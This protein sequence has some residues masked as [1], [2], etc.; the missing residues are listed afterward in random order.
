M[1][2]G[3][4]SRDIELRIAA[5]TSGA[6]QVKRLAEQIDSLAK[7]GG[8]AAPEFRRLA[9]QLREV[10]KQGDALA[11]VQKIEQQVAQTS[12][13][14]KEAADNVERLR[15]SLASQEQTTAGFR[16]AQAQAKAA[17]EG[18][19]AQLRDLQAQLNTIRASY[20]GAER[21]SDS[22]RSATRELR[23][24]I[25]QVEN[26]LAS[27]KAAL[28]T[29]NEELR[30]SE[31]DLKAASRSY[32]GTA[33]SAERL[34]SVIKRQSVALDESKVSLEK[35]GIEAADT[36]AAQAKLEAAMASTRTEADRATQA[37]RSLTSVSEAVGKSNERNV[38]LA[39]QAAQARE[40]IAA[41]EA[42]AARA[43]AKAEEDAALKRRL[44]I[45]S[46]TEAVR[47]SN[48][49]N[50]AL[51]KKA[52]QDREAAANREAAAVRAAAAA[53]EAAALKQRLALQ[54]QVDAA[55][56]AEV[57]QQSL[58]NAFATT[59]VRSAAV[60][61]AEINDLVR[62]LVLLKNNAN[63]SGKEFD[64]AFASAQVRFKQ[65]NDELSKTPAA[66]GKTGAATRAVTQSLSQLA[67]V[68]GGFE[69][70]SKF[71][72]ANFQIETLR[73]SLTLVTGST[74]QAARQIRLLQETA[75]RAGIS[76]GE[77]S[78]AYV[79]FQASLNGANIP[80]ATTESLFQAV[81]NASGQ[82]G[83]S[84]QRTSL[85]L[86]ALGQT[87][88]KGV[89]SMEELRQQLGDSL[90]GALD[91]TAKGL[92][93]ST[94]ELV[95]LT[96][97]G[98]LLAADFLPALRSA[99]IKTYGDGSK[100]IDGFQASW[101]RLKNS[102]TAT[103]QFIGDSGV[104]KGL[105][106]V[107]DQ[108]SI[109]VRGLTGAVE[110]VGKAFGNWLG[111]LATFDWK[112]PID[113]IKL[114]RQVTIETAND[115]QKRL[116]AAN[117][118]V[119]DSGNAA[120]E[121]QGKAAAAAKASGDAAQTASTQHQGA[122]AAQ[123]TAAGAASANASAQSAAG[124]ATAGAGKAASDA[125]SAWVRL[126]VQYDKIKQQLETNVK[127]TE[128]LADAKKI[129]GDAAIAIA[130]IS[131]NEVARLQASAKAGEGAAKSLRDVANARIAETNALATHIASLK[132]EAKRLGDGTGA[133]KK[134]IDDL[135]KV[136]EVRDAEAQKA[137]DAAEAARVESETRKVA[138]DT[139]R[140]NT[141][142]LI[143][144][145]DAYQQ[146]T[147]DL[148]LLQ[149]LQQQGVATA[150]QVT[151]AQERQ[152]KAER[153]Y[154][155]AVADSQ[156]TIELRTRAVQSSLSVTE[157][158]LQLENSEIETSIKRAQSEGDL[159]R[160]AD[161]TI[162]QKRIEIAIIEAK[163]AAQR[164]EIRLTQI[165]IEAE[166]A[167]LDI[168]DPLYKQKKAELDLRIQNLEIK[169]LEIAQSEEAVKRV[170]LEIEA[171]Q[172]RTSQSAETARSFIRDRQQE[173]TALDEVADASDR[174]ADAERRR[175][176][177]DADGFSADRQG[178]RIVAGGETWLSLYNQAKGAGLTDSAAQ[179]LAGQFTD[180]QGNVPFFDNPGQ[181]RYGGQGSTLSLAFSNAI[182][183]AIRDGLTRD[184]EQGQQGQA[185][186]GGRGYTVNVNI[187][188]Q[189]TPVQVASQSDAD[190]LARLLQQIA[191]AATR[192]TGR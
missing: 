40:E 152:A 129:E 53:A 188:G 15:V 79:K 101:N 48:E 125:T 27:Q 170:R 88:N 186:Q 2:A 120:A 175:R 23:A 102:L 107:L 187:G 157:A 35:L 145:R 100:S 147:R 135:T 127:V 143:Q 136:L 55:K 137:L 190:T 86:E 92:G 8:D 171:L 126:S 31:K 139:Y 169:R 183:Q 21:N 166:R 3:Q 153:L 22:Y 174:A 164:E 191:S 134:V 83:L 17:V 69:L 37:Y 128:R 67:A 182:A 65:L 12:A 122:A 167:A 114:Y 177:V 5:V 119:R 39:R 56:Q 162:R 47:V 104:V 9:E 118:V 179:S 64:R 24:N 144:L 32:D 189:V 96:E 51:A 87:A 14:F 30:K 97:S 63:V 163:A 112:R 95:K 138:I 151:A 131:G 109:A 149:R 46:I 70:A 113:S 38:A 78:Q 105:T 62:S 34:Q 99:L 124:A 18:T 173:V 140:D 132:E 52:A 184:R 72:D 90:P 108:A 123:T 103:A 59:G 25:A 68:Y 192:S 61:Q 154:R 150:D 7:E 19:S 16:Q 146:T 106:V 93:I 82:L 185:Q 13:R 121:A 165:Q 49:R 84:S 172:D 20:S 133:R 1:A 91:L 57:A 42:A 33:T 98:N 156:K 148:T 117:G 159:Q 58:N 111:F 178:N 11:N 141:A 81:I 89:V 74:E 71:V 160:V 41:R 10:G 180:A 44:S 176:R 45:A 75:N 168:A 85:I 181:L 43:A 158:K 29:A 73:R 155:D 130:E 161:L 80:L 28:R 6:E 94:A 50:V 36:A 4:N 115:I 77:I 110:F 76:V 66:V 26:Q 60:I 116:D 142:A 54:S